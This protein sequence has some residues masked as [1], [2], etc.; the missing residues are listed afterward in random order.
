[1]INW[2]LQLFQIHTFLPSQ[3]RNTVGRLENAERL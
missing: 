1:M 2:L 3:V